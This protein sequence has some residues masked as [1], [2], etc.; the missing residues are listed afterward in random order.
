[1]RAKVVASGVR[2]FNTLQAISEKEKTGS[3]DLIVL[4]I[5]KM[6]YNDDEKNIRLPAYG[7]LR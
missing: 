6:P 7:K 1:M 4:V 2:F 3:L 5:S